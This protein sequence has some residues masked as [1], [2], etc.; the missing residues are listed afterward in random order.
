MDTKRSITNR[1]INRSSIEFSGLDL[2]S[3]GQKLKKKPS[4]KRFSANIFGASFK[5]K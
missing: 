1:S 5:K 3:T 4:V 2:S